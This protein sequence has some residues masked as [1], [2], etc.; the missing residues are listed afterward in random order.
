[1]ARPEKDGLVARSMCP[2]DRR[3]IA[4]CITP[5]GRERYEAARP[6]HRELLAQTLR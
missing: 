5:E 2:E 4:V 6:P 3:G 1:V